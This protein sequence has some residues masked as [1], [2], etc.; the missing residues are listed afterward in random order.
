MIS[1][2]AFERKSSVQLV[3]LGSHT[4]FEQWD[5]QPTA[6]NCHAVGCAAAG[7]LELTIG[8]NPF[9]GGQT[10]PDESMVNVTNPRRAVGLRSPPSNCED[11]IQDRSPFGKINL[12]MG[13]HII[14]QKRDLD[15]TTYIWVIFQQPPGEHL[16]VM[17]GWSSSR[18]G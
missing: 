9:L 5:R 18:H 4:W 6:I 3:G 7:F 13:H 8:S 11:W 2:P 10:N 15:F 1:L 16:W 14:L 17:L 12:E